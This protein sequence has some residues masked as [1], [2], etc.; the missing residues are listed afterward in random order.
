MGSAYRNCRGF[1]GAPHGCYTVYD[2]CNTKCNSGP[3]SKQGTCADANISHS[4]NYDLWGPTTVSYKSLHVAGTLRVFQFAY[5]GYAPLVDLTD[6][7]M[8]RGSST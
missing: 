7:T 6:A 3:V 8:K 2:T 4:P 5:G 1:R